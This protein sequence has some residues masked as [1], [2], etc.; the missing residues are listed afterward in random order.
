MTMM[1]S[2]T[3]QAPAMDA[4]RQ[5]MAFER[6]GFW[7]PVDMPCEYTVLSERRSAVE[8]LGCPRQMSA[9]APALA[10]QIESS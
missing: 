3:R 5:I 2:I 7:Q 4:H 1:P 6:A 8:N 10:R 9:A